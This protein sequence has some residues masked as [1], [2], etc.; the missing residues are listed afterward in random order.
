[1]SKNEYENEERKCRNKVLNFIPLFTKVFL[2]KAKDLCGCFVGTY[3]QTIFKVFPPC[4]LPEH[5]ALCA[6]KLN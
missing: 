6:C 2:N 3:L 1:M 4:Y 5:I